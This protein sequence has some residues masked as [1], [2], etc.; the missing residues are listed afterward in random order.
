MDRPFIYIGGAV[1]ALVAAIWYYHRKVDAATQATMNPNQTQNDMLAQQ[2]AG[3]ARD[4]GQSGDTY[5]SNYRYSEY[6]Q[7][8][9]QG[10][11]NS[12]SSFDQFLTA[13][14]ANSLP[15]T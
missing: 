1:V 10:G 12:G 13:A 4:T 8:L 3:Y 5:T 9:Q 2:A 15:S 6:L 11:T 14:Q 7:Y